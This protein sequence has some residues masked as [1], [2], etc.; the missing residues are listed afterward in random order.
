MPVGVF[1]GVLIVG[2]SSQRRISGMTTWSRISLMEGSDPKLQP[3]ACPDAVGPD[4]AMANKLCNAFWE[5]FALRSDPGF[6]RTL[7]RRLRDAGLSD[8]TAE[9]AFSFG[10][11]VARGMQ[12]AL[13]SHARPALIAADL[14]TADEI[15]QHLTDLDSSDLDIAIFPIVSASGCKQPDQQS[16]PSIT[17]GAGR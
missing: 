5:L 9:V 1:G 17:R 2:D 14:A 16:E 12:H 10:G 15:D 8:V 6:G 11:A 3:L 7:P 4:H 13:I